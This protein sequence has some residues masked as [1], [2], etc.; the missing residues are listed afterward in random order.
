MASNLTLSQ[1][2]EGLLFYKTA[3]GKSPH[4][5]ADYRVS[6]NKL[7]HYF[8]HNPPFASITREQLVA[9]FA[10][11]QDDY[12]STTSGIASRKPL[13]LSPKT[14]KNIHTALSA[15]WT[16]GVNEGYLEKNLVRTIAPPRVVAP[17]IETFTQDEVKAMLKACDRDNANCHRRTA[18]RDHAI[19]L[20]LLDAGIRASELC[21]MKIGNINLATGSI[22]VKGKGGKERIVRVGRRTAQVLWKYLAPRLEKARPT[23]L[24]FVVGKCGEM[25]PMTRHVLRTL[26]MRI[27]ERAGVS[28]VHPHKFRHTFAINYLRNGGDVFTLQELLGHSDLEMV[29]RYARVAQIDCANAHQQASPVDNWRL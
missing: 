1:A 2:I 19:I 4:T 24:V 28:N 3:T 29:K 9:F 21:D 5:I 22:K 13:R 15:L 7:L 18:D 17:V 26:L 6:L 23:D 27:G 11:L 12:I 25:R 8:D 10:W 14:I 16:W 20:T